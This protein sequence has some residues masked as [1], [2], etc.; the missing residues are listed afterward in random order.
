MYLFQPV[1]YVDVDGTQHLFTF[2]YVSISTSL[3]IG[4]RPLLLIF[5][6]H[7]VSIS[8][9][10]RFRVHGSYYYLHST[11]YL[12]QPESPIPSLWI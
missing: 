8:T 6:F 11:M 3:Q 12:F 7:Y 10:F 1:N 5:T 9:D 2:H 4:V